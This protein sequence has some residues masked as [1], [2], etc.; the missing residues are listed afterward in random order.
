MTPTYPL[1]HLAQLIEPKIG[2][3]Y[4]FLRK[5]DSHRYQWFKGKLEGDEEETGVMGLT[6]EDAMREAIQTWRKLPFRMINCGFR[7]TLPE[8]DEHGMNALFH[9]M[10]ASYSSMN[11]IYFDEGEGNNC[12][13]NFASQEAREL[14]QQL[15]TLNKL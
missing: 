5:I 11:G 4:L 14:W 10:I 9:Q 13:I 15:K 2:K 1:I 3:R 12:F 6:V 8:R 7:Y